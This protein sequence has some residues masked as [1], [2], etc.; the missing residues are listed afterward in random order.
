MTN[1]CEYLLFTLCFIGWYAQ[2][3]LSIVNIT[4]VLQALIAG[5]SLDF[6]LYGP[7]TS[8]LWGAVIV[9]SFIWGRG[10]FCG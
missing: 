3:Q 4:A 1:V 9:T 10:T 5:R 7:M 2:G 6:F 8:I